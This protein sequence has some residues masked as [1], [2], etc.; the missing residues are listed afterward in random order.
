MKKFPEAVIGAIIAEKRW[1]NRDELA[2]VLGISPS[3][4][5]RLRENPEFLKFVHETRAT[6]KPSFDRKEID[7]WMEAG[8]VN[9]ASPF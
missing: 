6:G 5:D 2:L 1:L 3:Q 4:V 9:P 8:K 7:R